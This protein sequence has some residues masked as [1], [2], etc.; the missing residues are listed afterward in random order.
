[1]VKEVPVTAK[2]LPL[3][4]WAGSSAKPMNINIV[5][6]NLAVLHPMQSG[7]L[8]HDTGENG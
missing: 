6:E 3:T 7:L 2:M 1:M 5:V 4:L 8:S